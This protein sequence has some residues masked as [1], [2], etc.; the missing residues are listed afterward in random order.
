MATKD[1]AE[2][3]P[4]QRFPASLETVRID[5]L[6]IRYARA[7]RAG[8]ETLMLLSPWPESLL[9]FLPIWD[10]LTERYDVLA[11]DLPG[12]GR[13]EG[14]PDVIA[15]EAMGNFVVSAARHFGLEKPHAIG[16]DIGTSSLL[17]AAANHPDVF[18][19]ITIGSG[20]A[21]YP[22]EVG[23][24]L[25]ELIAAPSLEPLMKI[26]IKQLIDGVLGGLR[27]YAVP[28]FVRDDYIAS[29]SGEGRFAESARLVRRYPQELPL[30][31]QRLGDISTPVLIIAGRHD[32]YVPVS[33]GQF[34][35]DRLPAAR[36]EIVDTGHLVWEDAAETYAKLVIDWVKLHKHR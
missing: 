1:N 9:A 22:L 36:L 20:G 11:L 16:P 12:F 13:S 26:D 10:S 4:S 31:K 2:R 34:L 19:S 3:R 30:L 6:S 25:K 7:P 5:G 27:N 18:A 23:S 32:P 21:A 14:R 24:T 15:P 35:V 8:A 29:Y 33:N 28:D 17:F